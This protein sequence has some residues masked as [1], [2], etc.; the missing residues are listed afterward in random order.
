[1]TQKGKV[2]WEFLNKSFKRLKEGTSLFAQNTPFTVKVMHPRVKSDAK[3]ALFYLLVKVEGEVSL[4]YVLQAEM[5][6]G[7]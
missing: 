1:M 2:R 3:P 6:E 4:V 5:K 7:R